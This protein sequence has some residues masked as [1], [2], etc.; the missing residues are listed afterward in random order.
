MMVYYCIGAIFAVVIAHSLWRRWRL[1]RDL[2][3]VVDA[4]RDTPPS[5]RQLILD[6]LRIGFSPSDLWHDLY[7]PKGDGHYAQVDAIA[8]TRQGVVVFEVKDYHGKIYGDEN[9]LYWR[10]YPG[11]R[12][13]Y[14]TFYSPVRQNSGHIRALRQQLRSHGPL[15]YWSVVVFY[16]DCRLKDTGD[17]PGDTYVIRAKRL[18]RTLREIR[19]SESKAVYR[20][21]EGLEAMLDDFAS[22]GGDESVTESHVEYVTSLRR[23]RPAWY[24]LLWRWLWRLF[25]GR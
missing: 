7:V 20:D 18:R 13:G 10:Q 5:E 19:G 8:I 15:P 2:G 1:N 3:K 6:L 4:E 23:R 14:R 17:L 9:A 21:I 16:G 12:R 22:L 25:T 11:G 24:V